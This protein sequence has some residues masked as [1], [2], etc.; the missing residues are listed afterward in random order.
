MNRKIKDYA[1]EG[2]MIILSLVT[3]TPLFLILINS[4]K[5]KGGASELTLALPK[6]W[7]IVDNYV[8]VLVQG[9]MLNGF[10]NSIIISSIAVFLIVMIAAMTAFILQRRTT[11]LTQIMQMFIVCG[12]MIPPSIVPTVFILNKMQLTGNYLGIILVYLATGLPVS[13]FIYLGAFKSIPI[14]IDESVILDGGGTSRLFFTIIFPL[15]KPTT[16]TVIIISFMTIWNDVMYPLYILNDPKKYTVAL[17]TYFFYGE[18]VSYWNLVFSNIV[19]VSLP[20]VVIYFLLQKYVV[21]GMT[22]GAVKG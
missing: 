17:T 12:L 9:G 5:D 11:K 3:I 6:V 21:A 18:R 16:I 13:I 7:N 15:V 14:S 19:L 4:F 22:G 10:K 20:V 8:E 2:I 1:F